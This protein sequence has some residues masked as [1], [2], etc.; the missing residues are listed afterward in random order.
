MFAYAATMNDPYAVSSTSPRRPGPL[1]DPDAQSWE[2]TYA[3]FIHLTLLAFHVV[4]LALVL[5]PLILWLIKKNESPFIDDHG[6]EALNF[7]I[8]LLLYG[9]AIIPLLGVLTC[10]VGFILYLPV[11]ALGI[12]GTIF[13][14]IAAN[15]GEYYRYP[16]T[17]RFV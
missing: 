14:A 2:R 1:T 3:T 9:V 17:L 16:A 11:Y 4:P 6:R 5:A 8:S 10:G 15:K 7:H 12:L 13:A